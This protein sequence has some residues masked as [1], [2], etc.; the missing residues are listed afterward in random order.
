[1]ALIHVSCH[2]VSYVTYVHCRSTGVAKIRTCQNFLK[3]IEIFSCSRRTCMMDPDGI[4]L[5]AD[6]SDILWP[7]KTERLML[8]QRPPQHP[9]LQTPSYN[10]ETGFTPRW[11]HS[12]SPVAAIESW[13]WEILVA[14]WFL[15][16]ICYWN[17]VANGSLAKA[18]GSVSMRYVTCPILRA[19]G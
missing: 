12:H 1:M 18:R 10:C 9:K 7:L 13:Q 2:L 5:M 6:D 11:S 3:Y 17:P 19:H 8:K 15:P 14:G 16:S 4:M